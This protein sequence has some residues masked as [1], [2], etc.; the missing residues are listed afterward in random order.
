L[1]HSI[2]KKGD[3]PAMLHS[4]HQ[5]VKLG[6]ELRTEPVCIVV[7][8]SRAGKILEVA[9]AHGADLIMLGIQSNNKNFGKHLLRPGVFQ[10]VASARCPVFIV[11]G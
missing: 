8:G 9:E 4:L 11:R 2:E 1:L 3:V 5:L 10:I 6:A 7:H